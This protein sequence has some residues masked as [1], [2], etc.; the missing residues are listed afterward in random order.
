MNYHPD[1]QA[2][3]DRLHSEFIAVDEPNNEQVMAFQ[4]ASYALGLKRGQAREAALQQRLNEADQR[5]DEMISAVRSVNRGTAHEIRLGT[6][7]QPVYWQRKEWIDWVLE[8]CD[9]VSNRQL[10]N[11]TPEA[12]P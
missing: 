9:E 6:D 4:D 11:P 1:D 2:E 12:K 5:L 10:T 7:D 3:I 8:L